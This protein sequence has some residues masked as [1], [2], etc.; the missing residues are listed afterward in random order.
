MIETSIFHVNNNS[1]TG[2]LIIGTFEKQA[3][4]PLKS[5][6]FFFLL[7]QVKTTEEGTR[8]LEWLFLS[9]RKSTSRWDV[10]QLQYVCF[11]R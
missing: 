3:Q 2:P 4:A 1:F 6:P 11:N 7:P 10:F 8:F 5:L 9:V